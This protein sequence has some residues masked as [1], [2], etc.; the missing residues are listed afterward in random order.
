MAH[1]PLVPML[2]LGLPFYADYLLECGSRS[3]IIWQLAFGY[4]NVVSYP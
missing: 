1:F 2:D 3:L 4:K